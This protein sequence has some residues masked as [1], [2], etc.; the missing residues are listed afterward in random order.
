MFLLQDKLLLS[1]CRVEEENH[2][3]RNAYSTQRSKR[4]EWGVS[5]ACVK[6]SELTKTRCAASVSDSGTGWAHGQMS[7]V[8]Q[9]ISIKQNN[10][11]KHEV[12][13]SS[14]SNTSPSLSIVKCSMDKNVSADIK[15]PQQIWLCNNTNWL[16]LPSSVPGVNPLWNRWTLVCMKHQKLKVE[17][18]PCLRTHSLPFAKAAFKQLI[19]PVLLRHSR[20]LPFIFSLSYP[21]FVQQWNVSVQEVLNWESRT[22]YLNLRAEVS[23]SVDLARPVNRWLFW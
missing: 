12:L 7:C 22:F 3:H 2:V 10:M 1:F 15:R 20:P 23:T 17:G 11:V 16:F 5:S 19:R 8:Q 18:K 14:K 9:D 21:E 13:S 6:S 4:R